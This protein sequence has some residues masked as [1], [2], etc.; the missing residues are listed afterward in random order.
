[1][2]ASCMLKA[3]LL[4]DVLFCLDFAFVNE[5]MLKWGFVRGFGAVWAVGCL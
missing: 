3:A 5:V 1:M 2:A 4:G